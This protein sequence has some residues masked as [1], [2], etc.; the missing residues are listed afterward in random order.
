LLYTRL[1]RQPVQIL[2][3]VSL[4]TNAFPTL[5][6]LIIL[7]FTPPSIVVTVMF[8]RLI[9][10]AMVPAPTLQS[11]VTMAIAALRTH[12]TLFLDANTH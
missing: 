11:V 1:T 12:V 3:T 8:A 4:A 10:V 5:V 2:V 7:A 9:L 6:A